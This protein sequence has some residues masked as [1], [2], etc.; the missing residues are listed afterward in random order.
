MSALTERGD[1][2]G[3]AVKW[4]GVRGALVMT[5]VALSLIALVGS[6]LFI[7]SLMNAQEVDPGFEVKREL[8]VFMSPGQSNYTPAQGQQFYLDVL[9]RVRALP[10]VAD[11]GIS[12]L[13][14]FQVGFQ[15]TMWP[16]GSD[17]ADPRNGKLTPTNYVLPGLFSAAGITMLKGRDFTDHDEAMTDKVV[18]VNQALAEQFWPAQEAIGKHLYFRVVDGSEWNAEIIAVVKTV[19]NQTL[20]EPPAPI[21]YLALRQQYQPNA[22]MWIRAKTGPDSAVASVRTAVQ[23]VD[24]K[25]NIRQQQIRTS[26][27]IMDNVLAGPRLG[28]QLL[29][30]FGLLALLLAA[31]GTYGVMSYTVSQRTQEIGIRIALGAQ[32]RDVLGLVLG[33]GMSM[34]FAGVAAGLCVSMIL[35]RSVN[36][37]LYG[38]GNFDGPSFLG[39]GALLVA[40][41]LLACMVPARRAMRVDPII[42]LRYE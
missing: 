25:M 8:M 10:M 27:S 11:A 6:G 35:I 9:A 37:L 2:P 7:H 36:S 22:A 12:T 31:I 41:G 3:S 40:V 39:A 15:S 20:G 38:I 28:A 34:V 42:A 1:A 4:Y 26:Q 18:I 29:G 13:G 14:P 23:G 5:Q 33:N 32:R 16:E 24:P 30:G 19:K 17:H 21:A